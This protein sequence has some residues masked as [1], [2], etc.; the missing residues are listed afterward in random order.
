MLSPAPRINC[1]TAP[2]GYRYAARIWDVEQPVA[3]IVCLHGIVSHSGWYQTSCAFLAKAGFAVYALDRRGSGLNPAARGDVDRWQ[4]WIEDVEH[5]LGGL[6]HGAPRV[7][8]G[9]S[10]GAILAA[11]VARRH[12]ELLAG[13]GLICPGLYA[14]QAANSIERTALRCA[15]ALGLH[16]TQV[17]IPLKDPALFTNCQIA[18]SYI[19]SD[20][21]TLRTF[22]I[23]CAQAGLEL[24]NYATETP[25]QIRSPTLLMLAE[26]DRIVLN[27]PV[28]EFVARIG[29]HERRVIEYPGAAHTL[30]FESDPTGYFRDLCQWC[31]DVSVGPRRHDESGT[32]R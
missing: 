31:Q 32:D 29:H 11:A 9:I 14:Q 24:A 13:L 23:R 16:R 20:P 25:E 5:F 4:T 30:E 7:L 27:R 15:G 10:W 18:R 12:S 6:P 17:R 22:S 3:N 26:S 28:R 21:F 1:F 19:A 2:D 8:L